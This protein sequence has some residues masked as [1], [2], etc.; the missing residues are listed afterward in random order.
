[1]N[2]MDLAFRAVTRQ[3]WSD[4]ARLFEARGGPHYCWCMAWRKRPPEA[5]RG[6]ASA[7]KAVLK[8]ALEARVNAGT[9]IGILGYQG[10]TPVA[11]VSIAPRPTPRRPRGR[12]R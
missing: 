4:L 7:R 9:P 11:W 1:M 6:D 2:D 5:K 10:D 12:R 8:S 3:T